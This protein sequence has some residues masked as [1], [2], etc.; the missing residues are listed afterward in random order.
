MNPL[1]IWALLHLLGRYLRATGEPGCGRAGE[2]VEE[3]LAEVEEAVGQ[4]CTCAWIGCWG[5]VITMGLLAW[6]AS[7][8]TGH[9]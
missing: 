4:G 8:L 2:Q 5:A 7:L 9:R 1:G 6:L 3:D